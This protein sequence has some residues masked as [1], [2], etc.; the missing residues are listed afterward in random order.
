MKSKRKRYDI[1]EKF[2]NYNRFSRV[3]V[4]YYIVFH[5]LSLSL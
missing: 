1:E 5:L 2:E 3:C 4:A